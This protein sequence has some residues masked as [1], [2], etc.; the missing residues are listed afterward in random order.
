MHH[1][2]TEIA[3]KDY[4][5]KADIKIP[6]NT[7]SKIGIVLAHGSIINRK[8]LLRTKHCFG[9]Y[10]CNE[11]GAYI[12]APDFLGE[13]VHKNNI[14]FNNYT[15]ILNISTKYL[16]EKHH[17]TEVMGFGHSMGC[18]VLANALSMNPY[19]GSIVNYGGPIKEIENQRKKN[20]LQYLITYLTK[21]DY[22]VNLR[23][24]VKYVFDKETSRYLIEVMLKDKDYGC[25]YYDFNFDSQI[26]KDFVKIIEQY[27]DSLQKWGKPVLLLFGSNDTL[28][29]KTCNYYKDNFKLDNITIKHLHGASHVTPCMESLLNLSKLN[30][31]LTF[32][33][34]NHNIDLKQKQKTTIIKTKTK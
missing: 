20:F 3:T 18:Y 5:I 19:M 14:S 31:A 9:E 28:T 32:Y 27:F 12:I 6:S 29:K 2:E 24:L 21:Y 22:G 10:L 33:R 17:L 7:D 16:V 11:L 4:V 13:T 30:P 15:E 8:S 34:K 26:V 23:N 25:E 1:E